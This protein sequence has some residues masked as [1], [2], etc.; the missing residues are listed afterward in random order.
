MVSTLRAVS[1]VFF[2]LT[3][4]V[5]AQSR[6]AHPDLVPDGAVQRTYTAADGSLINGIVDNNGRMLFL[7]GTTKS[8]VFY[9]LEFSYQT[10]GVTYILS[11][12]W[13]GHFDVQVLQG[14]SRGVEVQAFDS[15]SGALF[16]V[17]QFVKGPEP[18]DLN[19][20]LML[21]TVGSKLGKPQTSPANLVPSKVFQLIGNGI[22][23]TFPQYL[24][25]VTYF[26]PALTDLAHSPPLVY[27]NASSIYTKLESDQSAPRSACLTSDAAG[28]GVF[29]LLTC[30]GVGFEIG[31]TTPV[32]D[33]LLVEAGL[34][35]T[36]VGGSHPVNWVQPCV[37][38]E[39]SAT[40]VKAN[41][42]SNN[43]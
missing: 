27:S 4:Q 41:C 2:A 43:Y 39:P 30:V 28:G 5:N 10:G 6:I 8:N 1:F 24:A 22:A 16:L 23:S 25:A 38:S 12:P 3:S 11:G 42:T 19:I 9:A 40:T 14:T 37:M 26:Q 18:P 32:P 36:T 13:T 35:Y 31:Q 34:L 29:G 15:T 7:S 33:Q 21:Y 20:S 17:L